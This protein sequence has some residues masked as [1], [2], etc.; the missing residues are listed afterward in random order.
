MRLDDREYGTFK[1]SD[2]FEIKYGVNLELNACDECD[3]NTMNSVNFVAR[4][5]ENNGTSSRVIIIDGVEPQKAGLISVAGGGSVLST[6]LQPEPFYSGRDLYTL[7]AKDNISNEAKMFVVTVIEQNKYRYSYGRQANK[8]LPDLELKLPIKKD[9]NP[10]WQFMEEYIR[11]LHHK[12]LTTKNKNNIIK[13]LNQT[14]WNEFHFGDLISDIYKA[15]AINKDDLSEALSKADSIRYI[16]RTGE[17]NGCEMLAIRSEISVNLIE[18]GNAISIG[19]TTATCFYQ[20]EDFI[21]GDHMVIVRADPW[22]NKYTGLFITAILQREQY[23]Y[24]YGR[25]Y[26]MDRIKDTNIKLPADSDG[27]PDWLFMENYIKSL[28]YGDRLEG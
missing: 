12:P 28:P 19:D 15:K 7:A 20:D 17:N 16:T 11:S 6:F 13:E 25:A 10:D 18:R 22:L 4:T 8:T 23:K 14:E 24:S 5:A 2:L 9:G 27:N 1:V 26:L 21:T 3:R